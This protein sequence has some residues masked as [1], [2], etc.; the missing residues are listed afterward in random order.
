LSPKLETSNEE[1]NIG[2]TYGVGPSCT[3][4]PKELGNLIGRKD[5]PKSEDAKQ[6]L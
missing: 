2:D 5:S 1:E 4:V 3:W 6:T